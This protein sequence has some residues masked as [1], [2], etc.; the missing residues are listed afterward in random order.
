M[1]FKGFYFVD[2]DYVR[3]EAQYGYDGAIF[4]DSPALNRF[5]TA[6]TSKLRVL[7]PLR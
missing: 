7:Q 4:L 1:I 6:L 3:G 5:V 2:R